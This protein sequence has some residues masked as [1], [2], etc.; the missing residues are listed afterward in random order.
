MGVFG[1]SWYFWYFEMS[2][3]FLKNPIILPIP[4]KNYS[5][6]SFTHSLTR[7]IDRYNSSLTLMLAHLDPE[8]DNLLSRLS[9]VINR[10]ALEDVWTVID[11][12]ARVAISS[13]EFL[14]PAKELGF[15]QIEAKKLFAALDVHGA[16]LLTLEELEFLADWNKF[17]E[18]QIKRH[19]DV[20]RPT[21]GR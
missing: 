13:G 3:I 5:T 2:R 21:V 14:G 20:W 8:S 11:P 12:E 18:Q 19:V 9:E 7:Y 15:T 4:Y 10:Y 6:S 1:F 16:D 17:R